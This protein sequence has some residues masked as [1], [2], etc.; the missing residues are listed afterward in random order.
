MFPTLFVT[1][2]TAA[3]TTFWA[4]GPIVPLL[5]AGIGLA[6]LPRIIRIV[7]RAITGR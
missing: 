5:A 4:S 7:R 3:M 2:V 1:D 6:L